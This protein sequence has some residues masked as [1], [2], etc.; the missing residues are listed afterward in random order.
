MHSALIDLLLTF[1]RDSSGYQSLQRANEAA[2]EFRRGRRK[3]RKNWSWSWYPLTVLPWEFDLYS[4]RRKESQGRMYH[5]IRTIITPKINHKYRYHGEIL[6]RDKKAKDSN[7]NITIIR[8]LFIS[9]T[10]LRFLVW[11]Y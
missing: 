11:I 5:S 8:L 4:A 6:N 7:I 1:E 2:S 9:N 10:F 3:R